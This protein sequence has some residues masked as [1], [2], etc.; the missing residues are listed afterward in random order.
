MEAGALDR[1]RILLDTYSDLPD[2]GGFAVAEGYG[3]LAQALNRDGR[4]DE[5][6]AAME[7][8][9]SHG[10]R[11]VPDARSDIA[12]LHL[13]AGREE[14]AASIWKTLKDE[15][16]DDV[17]LYNAAGLSYSEIG[18][19]GLAV[20]W[21]AEG[22]EVAMAA[23]DLETLVDQL[24]GV[25]R[26]SLAALGREPD[27]LERRVEFFLAAKQRT[28]TR[29]SPRPA[30]LDA[31]ETDAR[32]SDD[33]VGP[34][35]PASA[36]AL[37]ISW[38]PSGEYEAAIQ[39]WPDLAELWSEVPHPEYAQ[40]MDG[41]IKWLR[42]N[43][44]VVRAVAPIVLHD[45]LVWCEEHDEDP[46]QARAPYAANL[47]GEGEVIA[48]PPNRNEPCWCGSGRKYKKCCAA[49]PPAPMHDPK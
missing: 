33:V 46:Q 35:S 9:I 28:R 11:S 29:P 41:H 26:Q 7:R 19:H 16:P 39:R 47:L 37:A 31:V 42:S 2:S 36:I 34:G 18:E 1:A 3:E 22:I 5:A 25:R 12:E 21:L 20:A 15:M 24:S 44:V 27:E 32:L 40:R 49:S 30:M 8:A 14:Q 48:W 45:Y 13:R 17:W 10:W 4:H 6:I 43:Q 38:F 23:D